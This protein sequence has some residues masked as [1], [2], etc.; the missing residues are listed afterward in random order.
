[1]RIAV[2]GDGLVS[3]EHPFNL[4]VKISRKGNVA[5]QWK[6]LICQSYNLDYASTI[7]SQQR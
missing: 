1:M 5:Y 4:T 2:G 3:E 6:A 7:R